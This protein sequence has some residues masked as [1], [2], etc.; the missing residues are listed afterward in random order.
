MRCPRDSEAPSSTQCELVSEF[1]LTRAVRAV[2]AQAEA[3]VNRTAVVQAN[4]PEPE[5]QSKKFR[6]RMRRA[7]WSPHPR[8]AKRRWQRD[9]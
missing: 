5:Y 6:R 4:L 2:K 3:A 9:S 1:L 8:K 7:R